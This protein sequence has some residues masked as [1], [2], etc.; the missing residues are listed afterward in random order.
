MTILW[1]LIELRAIST[2]GAIKELA[3]FD[4]AIHLR[5]G[6]NGI[7]NLPSRADKLTGFT[8]TVAGK[9]HDIRDRR[10]LGCLAIERSEKPARSFVGRAQRPPNCVRGPAVEQSLAKCYDGVAGTP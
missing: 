6:K 3:T 1:H 9:R 10:T 7:L 2:A 8:K 5:Q 4:R